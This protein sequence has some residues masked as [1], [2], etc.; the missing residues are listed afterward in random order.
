ML[1]TCLDWVSFVHSVLPPLPGRA[2]SRDRNSAK[3]EPGSQLLYPIEL[4]V[5]S[6]HTAFLGIE[7]GRRYVVEP[8]QYACLI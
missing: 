4:S 5:A 1:L 2:V 6:D 3:D 8:R 7:P